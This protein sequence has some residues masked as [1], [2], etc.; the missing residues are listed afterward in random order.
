MN[1]IVRINAKYITSDHINSKHILRVFRNAG[2][3]IEKITTEFYTGDFYLPATQLMH[4][5]EKEALEF[6]NSQ[7]Y[8]LFIF[9]DNIDD[10]KQLL[11]DP[12][13]SNGILDNLIHDKS[14]ICGDF[15]ANCD[16]ELICNCCNILIGS[17]CSDYKI[18]D[19][20]CTSCRKGCLK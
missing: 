19:I 15:T 13:W 6:I 12:I 5:P 9:F 8:D 14:K 4:L 17:Y 10:A 18:T 3:K 7:V 2:R 11:K 20:L 16:S 1:A